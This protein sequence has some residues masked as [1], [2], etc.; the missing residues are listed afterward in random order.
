M[1]HHHNGS[2]TLFWLDNWMEGCAL[3]DNWPLLF[4]LAHNKEVSIR[5]MV[6]RLSMTPLE[7]FSTVSFLPILTN[8]QSSSKNKEK[9][10]KLKSS[11][12]F[13]VKTFYKFLNDG[14]I[15]CQKTPIILKE[16]CPKKI[17]LFNWVA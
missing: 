12:K 6:Y 14:S 11:G 5:D 10:W 13:S 17:N 1:L 9:R 16:S 7:T 4:Q 2:T 15:R 3:A 8:A